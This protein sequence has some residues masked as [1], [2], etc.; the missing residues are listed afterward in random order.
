MQQYSEIEIDDETLSSWQDIVELLC[1]LIGIPSALVMRL[2]DDEIQ[3]FVSSDTEGNPY[4][5]GDSEVFE[6]SGL[7][8]ET[9]INTRRKLLVGDALSDPEWMQNPDIKLGMISYLGF[10]IFY[11]DKKPFGTICVLNNKPDYYSKNAEVLIEKFRDI[12]ESN[13]SI[14]YL[15]K[16]LGDENKKI[17]DYITEI[18]TLRGIIPFCSSCQRVRD[19]DDCWVT[20]NDYV[21]KNSEIEFFRGLCPTCREKS[22]GKY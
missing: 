3:V 11:P 8:C 18:K 13:I 1:S 15:N 12:I 16:E 4:H 9:V 22:E 2:V 5:V 17:I 6:N 19:A 7:Y 20:I 21:V 10:P 14:L